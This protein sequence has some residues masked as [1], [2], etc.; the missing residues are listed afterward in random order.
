MQSC[1]FAFLN[2]LLLCCSRWRRRR[3]CLIKLPIIVVDCTPSSVSIEP[4][5][6]RGGENRG[7]IETPKPRLETEPN[8]LILLKKYFQ[9]SSEH[10]GQKKLPICLL[11]KWR[12]INLNI[13]WWSVSLFVRLTA[14]EQWKL[15]WLTDRWMTDNWLGNWITH[16]WLGDYWLTDNWLTD[17]Y[18]T[19]LLSM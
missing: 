19:S 15:N 12:L 8:S 11:I 4:W 18:M 10:F 3:R 14:N 16:F 5:V 13:T 6:S 17:K 7:C 9:I 2:L 1:W